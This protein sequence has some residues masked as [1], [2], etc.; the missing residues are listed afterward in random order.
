MSQFVLRSG[1]LLIAL[2]IAPMSLRADEQPAEK[3]KSA[4]QK[5]AEQD[6]LLGTWGGLRT[7][8]SAHG[9]DFEF[10][11]LGS[12]PRNVEGGIKT[13]VEYQ[14]A[15]LMSLD[16][17]SDKLAGYHGGNFHVSSVW[18]NGRDHFSDEHIGDLNRVNLVDFPNSFRLW[19]MYYSQ[20]LF[21]DKV[22][23]KAGIM[24]V[25]RDFIVP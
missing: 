14:G 2:A 7:N 18:L 17:N 23:A 1:W 6:Y 10:F 11:Y 16:L 3:E 12:L 5:F 19:E 24:S 8:L 15:L 25:D 9:V 20:K 4:F 22:T 21:S 13:G